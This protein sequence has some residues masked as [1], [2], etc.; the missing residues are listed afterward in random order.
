M[1]QL[2]RRGGT[3]ALQ[4]ALRV[5]QR[6][7]LPG[8]WKGNAL[9]VAR[10][11]PFKALN[12]FSFDMYSRALS[13][14][15][16]GDVGSM[17][18]LAGAAAGITATL[19]C[20]PLDTLRTRMMAPGGHHRYGGPLATLRGIA[21]HEGAGALYAG[22]VPAVV[23][24]APAGAVFYG[25]YDALK[26]RHLRRDAEA[27]AAAGVE[28]GKAAGGRRPGGGGVAPELPA[29]FTLLYGALA[30]V[31]SEVCIY[32]LEVLRRRMQLHAAWGRIALA[33]GA[34]WREGGAGGFYAGLRPSL[35]QVLPSAALSYWVYESV[36]HALGAPL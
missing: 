23:G 34:I 5:Y 16:G 24:M 29:G 7:G 30:G 26:S 2:L 21:R 12:F 35:L 25:V 28:G 15:L 1:D 27:A 11:A 20:F 8:F 4:T 19:V 18:F 3:S 14:H 31:A 33:A 9:N 36:K 17:R 22:C 6:E 32:P 10:T 13:R